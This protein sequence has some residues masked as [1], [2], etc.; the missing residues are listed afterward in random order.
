MKFD[1]SCLPCPEESIVEYQIWSTAVVH[2]LSLLLTYEVKSPTSKTSGSTLQSNDT[3]T[4]PRRRLQLWKFTHFPRESFSFSLSLFLALLDPD[5]LAQCAP[6]ASALRA[7]F[8]MIPNSVPGAR[9]LS[10]T[11]TFVLRSAITT[12]SF[13]SAT[14]CQISSATCK[15]KKYGV[16]FVGKKT[17]SGSGQAG[18]SDRRRMG[19]WR[20]EE[21]PQ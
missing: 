3:G 12:S 2:V 15:Q 6:P 11:A 10:S 4:G 8:A 13:L 9:A 7:R 14:D 16:P 21:R 19:N 20:D 17:K 1:L 18:T 5:P